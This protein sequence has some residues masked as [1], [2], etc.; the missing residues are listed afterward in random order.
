M[1]NA[2]TSAKSKSR[3]ESTQS[4]L[5]LELAKFR[6]L[7]LFSTEESEGFIS[8]IGTEWDHSENLAIDSKEFREWLN[9]HFYAEHRRVPDKGS[10][11][12]AVNC[13]SGKARYEGK[14][15]NTFVRVAP[16]PDGSIFLD[17][18]DPKWQAVKITRDGWGIEGPPVKFR[19]PSGMQ[20]LAEPVR[21]GSI[22]ELR[23]FVNIQNREDWILFLSWVVAALNPR[24]PYPILGVHGEQGSTKSMISRVARKLV[25][26]NVAMLR[27]PPH[28]D[29]DL[30]VA[31]KHSHV[32][33]YDNIS[34]ISNSLSDE[35]CRLATGGGHGTRMYYTDNQERIFPEIK[36]PL[37]FNAICEPSYRPDLLDRAILL[38]LE[39]PA[40][41]RQTEEKFWAG[42]DEAHPRIFGAILD[43]LSAAIRRLP[44]VH[45]ERNCR[46]ADFAVWATAAEEA[47]GFRPREFMSA[48]ERNRNRAHEVSIECS[49]VATEVLGLMESQSEW[50]GTCQRLLDALNSRMS[51][52]TRK[53]QDWPKNAKGLS[54]ALE[55]HAPNLR[56]FGVTL[57]RLPREGGT[58]KRIIQLTKA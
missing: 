43:A 38:Y 42:F 11:E 12:A 30:A 35:F 19:R 37:V 47:L 27:K 45:L 34:Q 41:K 40:E 33:A 23:K 17:L 3:S 16:G 10:V 21:G 48:Y 18:G 5:L 8:V 25:D 36:R 9:Y 1:N 13:L 31:A 28:N 15:E 39:I 20:P 46:M 51:Q 58:G 22:E 44:S 54:S 32:L 4:D 50:K 2:V 14:R 26:P 6:S 7:E 56:E 57:K 29:L 24:G 55:R 53:A 52:E 49:S